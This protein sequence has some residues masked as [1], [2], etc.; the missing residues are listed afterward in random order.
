MRKVLMLGPARNVKG[1][2]TTVIDNYYNAGLNKI[3]ELKYIETCNDARNRALKFLKEIEGKI[4]FYKEIDKYDVVHIHMA[5]RRSTFRKAKYA[6]IAKKKGKKVIL[7]IHGGEYK[8]F[9][10]EC[11]EKQ[12][13]YIKETFNLADKIIVLSESWKQYFKSLVNEE[14]I[15]VISNAIKIPNDFEKDFNRN[16]LLFLGRIYEQK[17]IYDLLEAFSKLKN[18]FSDIR[19]S[20]CGDGELDKI[21]KFIV[22]NN[23]T[24]NIKCYGWV[25]GKEK[26]KLLTKSSI[27]LLP[28]YN[29]GM[30]MSILEAMA[31]KN[32]VITTNVGGIPEIIKNNEN[33]IMIAPGNKEQLYIKIKDII[34]DKNKKEEI[35]ENA[36]RLIENKFDINKVIKKLI[37]IYR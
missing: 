13:E 4:N 30:P 5:S 26:E 32:I 7:H 9:Y 23:L 25:S 27:F 11:N 20:I 8:I 17:G 33:G 36:R 34:K 16:E 10:N 28:S 37:D 15:V 19:L 12:K 1:G 22:E 29:E 24:S 35:S 31:Y 3:V 6:H 14:K 18:E 2:M 21:N